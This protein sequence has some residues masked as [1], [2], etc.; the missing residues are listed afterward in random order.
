[1]GGGVGGGGHTDAGA[2]RPRPAPAPRD[3]PP[4]PAGRPAIAV[5]RGAV[6]QRAVLRGAVLARALLQR[7]VREG[8]RVGRAHPAAAR[9]AQPTTIP[10]LPYWPGPAHR[11]GSR[12]IHPVPPSRPS[13]HQCHKAQRLR[14][15]HFDDTASRR[16]SALGTRARPA[17]R[18]SPQEPPRAITPVAWAAPATL[19]RREQASDPVRSTVRQ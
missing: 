8:A 4:I 13:R 5:L 9:A 14:H 19:P 16:A 12:G 3:V 6:L 10:D 2:G 1:M 11:R 17:A 18:P 7:P 15:H